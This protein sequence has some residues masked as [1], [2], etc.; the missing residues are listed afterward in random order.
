M[1]TLTSILMMVFTMT[2]FTSQAQDPVDILLKGDKAVDKYNTLQYDFQYKERFADGKIKE[3]DL[4]LKVV[5][6]PIKKVAVEA[7]KPT[8]ATLLYIQGQNDGKVKVKKGFTLNMDPFAKLLMADTHHPIYRAGFKRTRDILMTTYNNRKEDVKEMVQMKGSITFDGRDCYHIVMTDK[9][10]AIVDYVVKKGDNC[11]KI[12]EKLGIPEMRI[13]E[14]NPSV[15]GYFG[16]TEGSTIKIPTS[17]G[18]VTTLY[19][20]KAN[21]LP[22]YQKV[23]DEKGLFAEYKTL[24]LKLNPTFTDADFEL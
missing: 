12:A 3:G 20:D 14:L 15:K 13:L 17:Y 16:L 5:E 9:K 19:I 1:K 6:G 24:N 10:Y 22:I 21:Y 11:V 4:S 23:E 18:K 2:F 7:R 8:K